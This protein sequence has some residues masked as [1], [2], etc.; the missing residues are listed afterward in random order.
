MRRFFV[1]AVF[2]TLFFAVPALAADG[3]KIGFI[4][5]QRALVESDA[6]KKAKADL[7][8]IETSK[9]GILE[10]KIKAMK[11]LEAELTT[12]ASVL[13]ADTKKA[14]EEE[15][16]KIQRDLQRLVADVRAEIQKKETELTDAILK[17]ISDIVD[18]IAQEQDYA[19]ILS[20]Q[21][22]VNAKKEFDITDLVIKKYNETKG[23]SKNSSKDKPKEKSKAPAK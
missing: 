11:K 19:I 7:E 12:Q 23:K 2:M 10:E 13:K 1:L 14:K 9:K 3:M 4:N 16:E 6:G 5:L 22:I 20:S 8:A 18:E 21:T 17:N 15:L